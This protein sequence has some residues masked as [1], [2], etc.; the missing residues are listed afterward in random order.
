M[1][2]SPPLD[3]KDVFAIAEPRNVEF[4]EQL[5][6]ALLCKDKLQGTAPSGAFRPSSGQGAVGGSRT[7]EESLLILGRTR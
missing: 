6:F 3:A 2:P 4:W 5:R 7:P 1:P